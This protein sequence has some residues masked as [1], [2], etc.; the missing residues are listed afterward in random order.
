MRNTLYLIIMAI[1][2]GACMQVDT[3]HRGVK[4]YWGEVD[5]KMGSMKEGL[6]WYNP[7]TTSIKEMNVK[8]LRWEGVTECYTRD[9]QQAKI[10]FVIN[11]RLRQDQAHTVY[12]DVGKNW[13]DILLP[14]AVEGELKKVIG[15]YDAID[16]IDH[17][18]EATQVAQNAIKDSLADKFIFVERFEMTNIDYT[19]EFEKAVESKQVAIQKAIEE[20]NRTKQIEEKAKQQVISAKAE[21]ESMRIRANA[22]SQNARLVQYE[23]VH[24]WDGKMPVYMLGNSVPFISIGADKV[25]NN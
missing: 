8:V 14:Q 20:T 18:K 12:R 22:L 7:I 10:N 23:A 5:E 3:G 13:A 16:L 15:K 2:L 21:A 6:Y 24:K 25:Q 4:V 19:D 11:Y 9:V 1:V 17:R